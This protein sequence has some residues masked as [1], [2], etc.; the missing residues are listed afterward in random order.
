MVLL[1]G[2]GAEVFITC[3]IRE[4]QILAHLSYKD[5]YLK[6]HYG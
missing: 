3:Q 1:I 4:Y 2:A 5:L 6:N